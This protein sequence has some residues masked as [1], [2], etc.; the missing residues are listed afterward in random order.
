MCSSQ[1]RTTT[2]STQE[3]AKSLKNAGDRPILTFTAGDEAW[4]NRRVAVLNKMLPAGYKLIASSEL[5]ALDR[6]ISG[7]RVSQRQILRRERRASSRESTLEPPRKR[8]KQSTKVQISSP[9]VKLT[10]E[11]STK[12]HSVESESPIEHLPKPSSSIRREL[13]PQT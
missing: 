11:P 7:E 4:I 10:S 6:M 5:L 2:C 12:D 8:L 3:S 9:C 1:D 13:K